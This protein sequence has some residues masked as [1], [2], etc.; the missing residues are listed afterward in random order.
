MSEYFS[1]D[2]RFDRILGI[3]SSKQFL[4]MEGPGQ[5]GAVF[6]LRL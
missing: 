2:A 6:Y 3:L 1:L 4:N 5:R